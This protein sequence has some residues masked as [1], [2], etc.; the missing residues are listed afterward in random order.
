MHLE[1]VVRARL[2]QPLWPDE[3]RRGGACEQFRR[4][5]G[6]GK[7]VQALAT[8]GHEH[9]QVGAGLAR[10]VE[11]P[12]LR[13]VEFQQIVRV[14]PLL[15]QP[16]RELVQLRAGRMDVSAVIAVAP[17][18]AR[19]HEGDGERAVRRAMRNKEPDHRHYPCRLGRAFNRHEDMRE[20]V[21][22]PFCSI[23]RHAP[24]PSKPRRRRQDGSVI[25]QP[26]AI[27]STDDVLAQ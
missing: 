1:E 21:L 23:R 17:S 20:H 2:G 22:P 26:A 25:G 4:D 15:P 12:R 8:M 7:G 19:A 11:D 9:D 16:A 27:W 10:R 5:A 3:Q 24:R 13:R 14:D 18:G 6:V